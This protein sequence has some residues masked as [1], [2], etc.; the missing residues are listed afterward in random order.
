MSF[1]VFQTLIHNL[2]QTSN[3]ETK[4]SSTTDY[5]SILIHAFFSIGV[6]GNL[7]IAG[8]C[9]KFTSHKSINRSYL[10]SISLCDTINLIINYIE[11]VSIISQSYS[12][13]NVVCQISNYLIS[14][15]KNLSA[16]LLLLCLVNN[17]IRLILFGSYT[18]GKWHLNL[19]IV[20]Q[21]PLCTSETLQWHYYSNAY[22]DLIH[23]PHFFRFEKY[24]GCF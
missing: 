1:E 8:Y 5:S 2:S 13:T 23:K 16:V 24:W 6:V 22:E 9:I 7:Y 17:A 3:N 21:Q 15:T 20:S 11:T 10:I 18:I 19:R 12:N 14:A 4:T